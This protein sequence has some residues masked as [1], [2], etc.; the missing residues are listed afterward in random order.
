MGRDTDRLLLEKLPHGAQRRTPV[1]PPK[2]VPVVQV[3]KELVEQQPPVEPRSLGDLP[4]VGGEEGPGKATKHQGNR[5]FKLRMTVEGSW[6][7]NNGPGVVL[8]HIS[9][10]EIPVKKGGDDLHATEQIRDL[11]LRK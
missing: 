1:L 3:V 7:I 8:S 10:P 6:V 9:C 11:H 5:Q 2:V 4:V